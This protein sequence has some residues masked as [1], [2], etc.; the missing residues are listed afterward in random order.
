MKKTTD[1]YAALSEGFN[2]LLT[3]VIKVGQTIH[4]IILQMKKLGQ[5]QKLS[6]LPATE[7]SAGEVIEFP[8]VGI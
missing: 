6:L 5:H 1:N 8:E 7:Y 2:F 4:N 3:P